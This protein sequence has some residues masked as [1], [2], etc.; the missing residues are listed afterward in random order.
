[1][2]SFFSFSFPYSYADMPVVV[3]DRVCKRRIDEDA[4]DDI[5][6]WVVV[7]GAAVSAPQPSLPV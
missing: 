4:Q 2:V 1:M 5:Y 6:H 7:A 3:K